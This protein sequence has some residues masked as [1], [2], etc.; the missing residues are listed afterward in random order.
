[1]TTY[2]TGNPLGSTD[3]RDLSDNAEN[4]DRAVNDTSSPT[5]TDRFGNTRTTL[6]GQVGYNFKGDYAAGIELVN[7]NDIIR[8]S[9]EFYRPS[10]SATLPYTT[11][12]TLP[13][14]DPNLS[15]V[16]DA[17]LRQD[18]ASNATGDGSDLVAYTGTGE[19]VTE[20]LDKRT[21]YVGSVAEL[22]TEP[23]FAGLTAIVTGD[24]P[25]QFSFDSS[26]LSAEVSADS[27]EA[28]YIAP[29]S[30]PTGASGAWVRVGLGF[31]FFGDGTRDANS[32]VGDDPHWLEVTNNP[33]DGINGN[34]LFRMNSY[35]NIAYGNNIHSCRYYGN[36]T[37]PSAIQ[38]GAFI[39]SWGFRGHDGAT[40][41][42]SA[43]AFQCL[44]TENWSGTAHGARFQFEVTPNGSTAREKVLE[45]T[46]K[47]LAV[48]MNGSLDWNANYKVLEVSGRG[49]AIR[50]HVSQAEIA[51]TNNAIFDSVGYKYGVNG[52][53]HTYVHN[54][55][56]RHV[57]QSGVSGIAGNAIS[58]DTVM[59][60]SPTHNWQ[61]VSGISEASGHSVRKLST[62]DSGNIVLDVGNNT[63]QAAF[64]AVSQSGASAVN[65]AFK[66]NRDGVT[67]RSINA[68][69]TINASGADY[70]EYMRKAD[71]CGI[72]AKGDVLGIDSNGELTDQF[73]LAL[74]FAIKSTAPSY[75]GGD[76]WSS[77]D[78]LGV[79]D[80]DADDELAR[81]EFKEHLEAER[82]HWD[83]VAFSGRVPV[84]VQGAKPG[85]YL[86]PVRTDSGGIA[87][88]CVAAPS[89]E[90]YM[91]A[92]GKVASVQEDGRPV[93]LVKVA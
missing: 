92:V 44:A 17:V 61:V 11:T 63:S 54:D 2:N 25:Y 67:G 26:N 84:N 7:Y 29:S 41:S 65:A 57:W 10:A 58:F 59:E 39:M 81:A 56:G 77:S 73:D 70:A 66:V 42:Q 62:S 6:A 19:T 68:G 47:G 90:Q 50:G 85:D 32:I 16:G 48:S 79:N 4:F 27:V 36:Q 20:A 83:R 9:G 51:M 28:R 15:P 46:N 1:M 69:G 88:E 91:A 33:G 13:D 75:V 82:Q 21:I 53:A 14:V 80:P 8:Y 87:A 24:K 74:S 89:F 71:G 45:V 18:L 38:D 40:L 49:S 37:T 12:A 60:I 30:D 31:G 35:G 52:Y 86:V 78:K 64:Y 93:V 23:F 72:I 43:A 5:W 55:D 76:I 3:P 34:Q 22:K